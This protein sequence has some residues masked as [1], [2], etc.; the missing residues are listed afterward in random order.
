MCG[1]VVTGGVRIGKANGFGKV[2]QSRVL[3]GLVWLKGTV[4]IGSLLCGAERSG[5]GS[6]WKCTVR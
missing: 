3:S 6:Q 2:R 5:T 1:A 4:W